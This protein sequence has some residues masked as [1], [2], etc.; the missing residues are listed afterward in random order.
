MSENLWDAFDQDQSQNNGVIG[1]FPTDGGFAAF[2]DTS[3]GFTPEHTP[4]N[5]ANKGVRPCSC[6]GAAESNAFS[7]HVHWSLGAR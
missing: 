6:F 4:G 1:G 3:V 7:E 5:E 2:G